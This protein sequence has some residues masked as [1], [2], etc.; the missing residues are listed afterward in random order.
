MSDA[1]KLPDII[2]SK[3]VKSLVEAR[4]LRGATV[5]GRPGG[6]AVL[7]RYGDAERAISGQ[8]SRR[9]RLWRHADSAISFVRT[10]LGMD[11]FDVDAEHF[12]ADDERRRPDASA[13]LHRQQEAVSHD[14]WF[15]SQVQEALDGIAAGTN[16]VVSDSDVAKRLSGLRQDLV[17]KTS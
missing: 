15:R 13:R 11:R 5:L 8:K 2:D 14:R 7:V 1:S 16:P 4:A 9:M 17:R 3:A 10:E 6:W 12:S